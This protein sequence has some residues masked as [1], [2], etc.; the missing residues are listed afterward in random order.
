LPTLEEIGWIFEMLLAP[1]ASVLHGAILNV[2]A[3]TRHGIH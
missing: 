3:G 2:D 1:E